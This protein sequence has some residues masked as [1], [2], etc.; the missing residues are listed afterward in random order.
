MMSAFLKRTMTITNPISVLMFIKQIRQTSK[1]IGIGVVNNVNIS[2]SSG[3]R[4]E[5]F[6]T[7]KSFV[8]HNNYNK[9]LLKEPLGLGAKFF[10]HKRQF[11]TSTSNNCLDETKKPEEI[12]KRKLGDFTPRLALLYKCKVCG[13]RNNHTFSKKSYEEGVVIVKC[14][15]CQSNHLIAD[16]LGWFKDV[17]KR[18]IEEILAAKGEEVK[19]ISNFD[20]PPDLLELLKKKQEE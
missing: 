12:K 4:R 9:I 20:I 10:L 16:N 3:L 19:K 11:N 13:T 5:S 1:S 6:G 2:I 8:E 7:L 14:C 15:N 17:N 18:N